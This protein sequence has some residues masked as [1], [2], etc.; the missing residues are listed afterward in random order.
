MPANSTSTKPANTVRV[1][2]QG[3]LGMATSHNL[4]TWTYQGVIL[5]ESYHLSYPFVVRTNGK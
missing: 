4:K 5:K 2:T 1:R 3:S